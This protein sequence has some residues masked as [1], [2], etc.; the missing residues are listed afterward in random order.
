[1]KASRK[2][3]NARKAAPGGNFTLIEL[4][5]VIAIIAILASMLL[6]ALNQARDRARSIECSSNLK[7][8]GTALTSYTIDFKDQF[9]YSKTPYYQFW[10]GGASDR[11]WFE[12]LGK[13]GKYSKLDYG[14]KLG[15]ANPASSANLYKANTFCAA[16]TTVGI[17][18]FP[19]YT[20]NGWFFGT[21]GSATY[22]NHNLN[23][24][25]NPSVII[26]VADNGQYNN[27]IVTYPWNA[28]YAPE[29]GGWAMRTNHPGY[30]ANMVFG[31]MHVASMLRKETGVGAASRLQ[32]GFDPTK[33][34]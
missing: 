30:T 2:F 4:L 11:P 10:D 29:Y 18:Q 23:M 6:P 13:L 1:M 22:H 9:M 20:A 19:D 28:I 7:Q 27:F 12:V 17:F 32:L 26:L 24:M 14:L 8:L 3:K 33:G 15:N 5:V 21:I 25:K 34:N 31:D 16:Q